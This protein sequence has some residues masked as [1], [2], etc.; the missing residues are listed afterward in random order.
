MSSGADASVVGGSTIFLDFGG[1]SR[2]DR[3]R[4]SERKK[5]SELLCGETICV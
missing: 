5:E 4:G 3:V 1:K 2:V